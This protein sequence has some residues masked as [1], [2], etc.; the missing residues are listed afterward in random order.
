MKTIFIIST[1]SLMLGCITQLSDSKFYWGN[2]SQTLYQFK[3]NPNKK[4][5]RQHK[6]ELMRIIEKSEELGV[7]TPPGIQ[8]EL[9]Y[10]MFNDGK[11]KRGMTL[12]K[13]EEKT[14]PES[15]VL[16]KKIYNKMKKV[17]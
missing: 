6:K 15:R 12:I 4:T 13:K 5:S 1:L 9:G 8:A 17:K 11:L 10:M 3:K 14:Y 2:Y 16:M 7:S